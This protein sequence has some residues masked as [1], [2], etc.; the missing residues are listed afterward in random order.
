VNERK[1]ATLMSERIAPLTL[2][3]GTFRFGSDS[4]RSGRLSGGVISESGMNLSQYHVA[5]GSGPPLEG[6]SMGDPL[7]T[8]QAKG[9]SSALR[10]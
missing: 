1:V 5:V 3:C 7:R 10:P 2:R 4:A 9:F 8:L 6:D